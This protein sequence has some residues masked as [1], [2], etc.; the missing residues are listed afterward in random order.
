MAVGVPA[1]DGQARCALVPRLPWPRPELRSQPALQ[2]RPP[3][4]YWRRA[5]P[6]PRPVLACLGLVLRSPRRR[7][8]GRRPT[9]DRRPRRRLARGPEVAAAT[10]GAAI[11]PGR[12]GARRGLRRGRR[13]AARR[14][15]PSPRTIPLFPQQWGLV[16]TRADEAWSRTTGVRLDVIAVVDT[17]VDARHPD[18]AGAGAPRRRLHHRRGLRSADLTVPATAPAS[19]A[20][21]PPAATTARDRRLLLGLHDPPGPG[22]RRRGRRLARQRRRRHPLG[23]RPRRRHHQPLPRRRQHQPHARRRHRRGPCRR[24]AIVSPPPAT[25]RASGQDLTRAAVPGEPAGGVIGVV[26]THAV[27]RR[28]L[29]DVPWGVGR[30]RRTRL[31]RAPPRPGGS[32]AEEC[33][34]SFASP[35]VA[36][37]LG[38]ALAAAPVGAR[39]RHRAGALATSAP[40]AVGASPPPAGVDAAALARDPRRHLRAAAAPAERVA[41]V[42]RIATAVA[43]SQRAPAPRAGTVIARPRRLLRR[44]PRCRAARR[45]A[46]RTGPADRLGGA[47]PDGGRRGPPARGDLGRL[48]RRRRPARSPPPWPPGSVAAGIDRRPPTRRRQPLRHRPADRR[49][50]RRQRRST[51]P[52]PA[53][54][55]I[56]VAVSGLA[57]LTRSPILLVDRDGVPAATAQALTALGATNVT[58]V[59]GAERRVR[60]RAV[61]Q[62]GGGRRPPRRRQPVRDVRRRRRRSPPPREATPRTLAGHRRRLARR[63]RRRPGVGRRRR[64]PP[65]GGRPRRR[66]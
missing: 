52:R 35:A 11:A 9:S 60:R 16:R 46:R 22:P 5:T 38:L 25:R 10:V 28:L 43:L 55:P 33:G 15:P 24:C 32:Y 7:R 3:C 41:G 39:R 63:A 56:A 31:R 14:P 2:C 61:Q 57:A 47:R 6:V 42:D 20:S 34:T 18:L 37:I 30:R 13:A 36:G 62:L 21:S 8:Q 40:S 19:P 12:A 50:G 51:S 66:R 58:V 27:R 53:A 26:A 49:R 1:R 54:G 17:G 48:A 65:P 23:D 29:V 45:E 59:G 4:R 64:R 44:R